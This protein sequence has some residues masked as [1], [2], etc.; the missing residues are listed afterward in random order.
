MGARRIVKEQEVHALS[1][2]EQ[3][4]DAGLSK[5]PRQPLDRLLLLNQTGPLGLVRIRQ[6]SL[7]AIVAAAIPGHEH[8]IVFIQ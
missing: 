8:A 5:C 6:A 4:G 7:A 1:I 2:Q 3:V